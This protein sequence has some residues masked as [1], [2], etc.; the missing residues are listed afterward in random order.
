MA[1]TTIYVPDDLRERMDQAS[2]EVNWSQVACRAF[3]MKLGELATT[4]R[5]KDMTD[6]IQRLRASKIE[7]EAELYTD[8]K[9]LGREWAKDTATWLQLKRVPASHDQ[10]FRENLID[11]GALGHWVACKIIGDNDAD[12]QTINEFWSEVVGEIDDAR[13]NDDDF[14]RGFVDGANE[15]YGEVASAV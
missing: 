11:D 13:V 3:E 12:W 5:E 9:D 2:E 8:G 6:V 15:I 1:R 14:I 10:M 7:D 4:K